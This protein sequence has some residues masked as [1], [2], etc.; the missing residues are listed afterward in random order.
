MSSR[1]WLLH[2]LWHF[3]CCCYC[4]R[5]FLW[6]W[7]R[8]RRNRGGL[9]QH[10]I[11]AQV[12]GFFIWRVDWRLGWLMVGVFCTFFQLQKEVDD[13]YLSNKGNRLGQSIC[14]SVLY[15]KSCLCKTNKCIE[16][17]THTHAH[18]HTQTH[19]HTL[20]QTTRTLSPSLSLCICGWRHACICAC[21]LKVNMYVS[22]GHLHLNA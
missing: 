9:G 17:G 2:C 4:C 15:I 19:T 20:T 5:P 11:L 21:F 3:C 8:V 6:L 12:A 14:K 16:K 7:T 1:G 22:C 13:E 18:T 10:I